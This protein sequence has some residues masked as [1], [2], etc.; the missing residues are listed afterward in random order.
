MHRIVL[1]LITL[2]L[3]CLTAL[4]QST[5]PQQEGDRV[6]YSA[7]IEMPRGYLSGVCILL[8]EGDTVK[9]SLFNEFGISALDFSYSLAKDKVKLHSVMAMLN[10]WYIK[11]V[12]KKDLRELMCSLQA[13]ETTYSDKK[14][15]IDYR[16][17]LLEDETDE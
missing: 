9:G 3:A 17:T 6:R 16:F 13:G 7:T 5:F 2:C 8:R 1:T 15:K 4:A 12:L 10:K 11:R 14:Y